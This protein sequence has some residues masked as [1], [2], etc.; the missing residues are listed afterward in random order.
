[1]IITTNIIMDLS[2]QGPM[3]VI[4][5][6]QDDRY[7][8]N[9]AMALTCG[10]V[11]W[12]PPEGTTVQI[13]YRKP[14]GTGG[15]YDALPDDT[16]AWTIEGSTLTVALAPQVCT[17]PGRVTL[18]AALVHEGAQLHTY[19]IIIDVQ[20][21]PGGGV[22]DGG[23]SDD[24]GGAGNGGETQ[25][26]VAYLYGTPSENGNIGLRSGDVVTYYEG[27]VLPKMLPL[28]DGYTNAH[29]MHRAYADYDMYIAFATKEKLMITSDGGVG[30][31]DG[32]GANGIS[33]FFRESRASNY[34]GAD[35]V[36]GEWESESSLVHS[37]PPIWSNYDMLSLADGNVA[38]SA[39]D[40][41]TV[42]GIVDFIDDIPIY[43]VV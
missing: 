12:E 21:N 16:P 7:S 1:M 33:W 13:R 40:P 39:S 9:I 6:V 11:A 32:V 24:T 31:S 27:A 19:P 28:P 2:R 26:S 36:W 10:S 37:Y 30:L 4:S 38:F 15:N 8:R 17:V 41:I 18:T 3:Q 14:D 23:A 22:N 20:P 42:G 43:E 25:E 34:N 5:A 29:I 35:L